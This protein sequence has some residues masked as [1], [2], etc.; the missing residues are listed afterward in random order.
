MSKI[1]FNKEWYSRNRVAI[2]CNTRLESILLTRE[3]HKLKIDSDWD[4]DSIYDIYKEKTCYEC[5]RNLRISYG[6]VNYYVDGRYMIVS[7]SDLEFESDV[8][9]SEIE[10]YNSLTK[11]CA[12]LNK[13]TSN[14]TTILREYVKLNN[15]DIIHVRYK[16]LY[17][18]GLTG[19]ITSNGILYTNGTFD[20]INIQSDVIDKELE[21]YI[22]SKDI[23]DELL[24]SVSQF[25][26]KGV[27]DFSLKKLIVY[28]EDKP[29]KIET[30][31]YKVSLSTN[32][33]KNSYYIS[34]NSIEIGD[35]VS[36]DSSGL[37]S[38]SYGIV[39]DIKYRELTEE[40]LK[41]YSN[42]TK[43]K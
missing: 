36:I 13:N 7:F 12:N 31:L 14:K 29:K 37:Y 43:I 9:E 27:L 25:L 24:L 23:K 5:D 11:Y 16:E 38:G 17:E 30:K 32:G 18:N 21:W 33:F 19:I 28:V 4:M 1:K 26:F 8:T 2:N 3:L 35:V 6:S 41:P 10:E 22:P 39:T 42:I 34:D 40:G 15:G 20:C